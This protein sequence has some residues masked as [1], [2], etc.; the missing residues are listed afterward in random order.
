M[1]RRQHKYKVTILGCS[2]LMFNAVLSLWAKGNSSQTFLGFVGLSKCKCVGRC[3]SPILLDSGRMW[4]LGLDQEL[5]LHAPAPPR[6]MRV[7]FF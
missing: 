3:I 5:G 4:G 2:S 1:F 6:S 7:G